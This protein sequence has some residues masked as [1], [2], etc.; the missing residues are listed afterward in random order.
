MSGPDPAKFAELLVDYCLEVEPA[1][2]VLIRSTT[3]AAP[4]MIEL[5]RAIMRRD[6][7]AILRAEIEGEQRVYYENARDRHLDLYPKMAVEEARRFDKTVGVQA[8]YA[9]GELAGIDPEAIARLARARAALREY[10]RDKRW[11]ST[12]WPTPALAERAGMSEPDFAAFVRK[13]LFLD[14]DD[15]IAAWRSLRAFQ[16]GL[17]ARIH[18]AQEIRVQSAGTD[19]RMSVRKRRWINSDGKRNM[20]SGEIFTSPVEDSVN[21]T[22]TFD[23]PSSPPGV[24][25]RG[26]RL[27]FRDGEVVAASA[28]QGEEYLRR[29]IATDEGARRVGE[30]GIGTN[31]GIDRPTGT[32]LYDEKIGGTMHIALGRSYEEAG[33]KNRSAIHWDLICDLRAGGLI[34]AD[35]AP[36]QQDGRFVT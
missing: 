21:G 25:V 22:I 13:A 18:K 16:D 32:I 19:L 6:A 35:G 33:G 3:L 2:E 14:Q 28:E 17:I 15:P 20:P 11:C 12:L 31:F 24:D 36:L 10:I 1:D 8:P 26:V 5:Q 9:L 29:T 7:F 34:T 4:L 27:E 30:I 23:I